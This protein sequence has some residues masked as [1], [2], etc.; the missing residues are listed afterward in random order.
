VLIAIGNSGRGELANSAAALVFD[1]SP[2]VRAM[3]AWALIRLA[4]EQARR[5]AP[6]ALATEAD[7]DVRKEW[8]A[9][10]PGTEQAA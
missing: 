3:A 5:L 9:L 2:L 8:L 1:T 7:A 6:A 10:P 4:P